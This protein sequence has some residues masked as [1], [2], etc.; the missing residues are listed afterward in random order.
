MSNL[1]ANYFNIDPDF[2]PVVDDKLI[3][4]K[5]DLWK[6]Y[7]PHETFINLL[8]ATVRVLTRTEKKSIWVE[9]A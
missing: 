6:S 3:E 9:G 1:Y 7:F 5:P 8:K 2:T 4:Q